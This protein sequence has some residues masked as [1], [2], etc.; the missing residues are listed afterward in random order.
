MPD[1]RVYQDK[2]KFIGSKLVIFSGAVDNV[3]RRVNNGNNLKKD[4]KKAYQGVITKKNRKSKYE[5]LS[6]WAEV[7]KYGNKVCN[8][9]NTWKEIKMVMVTLTLSSPQIH[10]DKTIKR[11]CL[12]PM[13]KFLYYNYGVENYFWKAESQLN[14]NIHFHILVDRYIDKKELQL[15]W[16]HIQNKLGYV[17]RYYDKTNKV[18]PPSTQIELF[19]P[20]R[21]SMEYILKYLTKDNEYRKIEGLQF[22][23]SN[24]L[25]HLK[26]YVNEI[27]A[28]DCNRIIA[29]AKEKCKSVY[30]NDY[31][32]IFHFQKE[33]IS[34]F[35]YDF[36]IKKM[37]VYYSD[38]FKGIYV[39]RLKSFEIKM[40]YMYH[41]DRF[42]YV[43]LRKCLEI[44][45]KKEFDIK[46]I[47]KLVC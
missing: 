40:V 25:S 9:E 34:Y 29:K 18:D 23:L 28:E 36:L 10:D 15:N 19:R 3:G 8:Y 6:A 39:Y 46:K 38:L 22:R 42:K 14:G 41:Q 7:L 32:M 12:E 33:S 26:I 24:K 45:N 37:S 11:E 44:E 47:E 30:S 31:S 43:M 27:R 2:I 16:N 21:Q 5:S 17:D 35:Q 1:S 20:S 4:R 13:L